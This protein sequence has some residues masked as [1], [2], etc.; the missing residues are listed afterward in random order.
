[1][2]PFFAIWINNCIEVSSEASLK[3]GEIS[4]QESEEYTVNQ[5][6]VQV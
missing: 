2:A 4:W 1:M 3:Q 6:T 5:T